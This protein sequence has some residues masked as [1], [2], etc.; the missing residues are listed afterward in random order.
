MRE[1]EH[2]QGDGQRERKKQDSLLIRPDVGLH[3]GALGP[4]PE[5]GSWLTDRHPGVPSHE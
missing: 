1:R 5:L 4:L 2:K 3:P